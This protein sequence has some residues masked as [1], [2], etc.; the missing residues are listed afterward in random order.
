MKI[1]RQSCD[2][3]HFFLSFDSEETRSIFE[4]VLTTLFIN[5][6]STWYGN[7]ESVYWISYSTASHLVYSVWDSEDSIENIVCPVIHFEIHD[8]SSGAHGHLEWLAA[9]RNYR[10]K[11]ES[12]LA[13]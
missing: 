6:G 8:V 13:S 4:N 12:L 5:E 2:D 1:Y 9:V 7:G 11:N 3:S 10:R